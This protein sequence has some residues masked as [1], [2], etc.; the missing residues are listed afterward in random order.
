[1][2]GFEPPISELTEPFWE[3][4]R[5]HRLLLQ[6]CNGCDTAVYYPRELCPSCLYA[7]LG[8]REAAGLGQVYS[9]NVMH[10]P[11]T[12]FMADRVPYVIALV[13]LEEGARIVTNVVNCD[14][15]DV[16]VGMAVRVTWEGLPDGRSLPVFEPATER[17]VVEP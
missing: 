1:M 14:P 12:P 15:A 6:W 2:P 11:G 3:A 8:W 4:T 9:Y 16:Q 17:E 10:R 7:D 5:E 13:D